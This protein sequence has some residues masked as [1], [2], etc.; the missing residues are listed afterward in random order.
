MEFMRRQQ[1]QTQTFQQQMFDRQQEQTQTFQRQMFETMANLALDVRQQSRP[2]PV[3]QA[4]PS[5]SQQ[6]RKQIAE[7]ESRISTEG[8]TASHQTLSGPCKFSQ[9]L[10]L[11]ASILTRISRCVSATISGSTVQPTVCAGSSS[12]AVVERG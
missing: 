8:T 9:L 2:L 3:S 6:T 5:N 10:D 11:F 12:A 1:E 4:G 7:I